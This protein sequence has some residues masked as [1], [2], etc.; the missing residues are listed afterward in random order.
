MQKL[1]R[2]MMIGAAAF[3]VVTITLYAFLAQ[4]RGPPADPAYVQQCRDITRQVMDLYVDAARSGLDATDPDDASRIQ[5]LDARAAAFQDELDELE[6]SANPEKWVY[7]SFQ[8]EMIEVE[9]YIAD[10]LRENSG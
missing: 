1:V 9:R 5:R 6:C 10:L 4:E 7:G 8:Q 2:N 3:A